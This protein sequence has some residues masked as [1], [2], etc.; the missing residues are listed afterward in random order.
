VKLLRKVMPIVIALLLVT[1]PVSAHIPLGLGSVTAPT[2]LSVYSQS[3]NMEHIAHIPV[4]TATG[5]ETQGNFLYVGLLDEGMKIYDISTPTQPVEVGSYLGPGYQ[6]DVAVSGKIALLATDPP[7]A[8]PGFDVIDISDPSNP[9]KIVEYRDRRAHAITLEGNLAFPSGNRFMDI[10]DLS[11]PTKPTKVGT[12]EA[13]DTIHDVKILG[14]RAYLAIGRGQGVQVVDISDITQPIGISILTDPATEYSHETI[15]N[16]DGSLIVM[17]D[18]SYETS[19]PGGELTFIDSS[20]VHDLRILSKF[21]IDVTGYPPGVYSV[22]N[23]QIDEDKI[24]ASWYSGG[25]RVIDISDPSNPVEVGHFVPTGALT[26]ESLTH[27]GYIYTGDTTRGIDVLKYHPEL[28]LQA[29]RSKLIA[30]LFLNSA[31]V[32]LLIISPLL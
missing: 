17:S 10:I 15:P 27:R 29:E 5:I 7:D 24:I 16:A 32:K 1:S 28:C 11:N 13:A 3:S 26:W 21:T 4:P 25:T 8:A 2:E 6:N 19:A 23:F 18:E 14:Q 30:P 9:T 20:N 31:M 22:H 12:F